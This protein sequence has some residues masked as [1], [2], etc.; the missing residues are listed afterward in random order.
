MFGRIFVE[1][2]LAIADPF[3]AVNNRPF[4]IAV[5]MF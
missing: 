2:R 5:F 3:C 1:N 4:F